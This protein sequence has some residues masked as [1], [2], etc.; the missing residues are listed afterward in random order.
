MSEYLK[1]LPLIPVR[2][3]IPY[4]ALTIL[5]AV[6]GAGVY[7]YDVQTKQTQLLLDTDGRDDN[8]LQGNGVYVLCRD[9]EQAH[10]WHHGLKNKDALTT[11]VRP[12]TSIV[13]ILI[14]GRLP[15]DKKID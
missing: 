1:R 4:N 15:I 6:D 3:I 7:A 9:D 12:P 13:V 8:V 11:V 2:S 5:M 10:Q 14:S